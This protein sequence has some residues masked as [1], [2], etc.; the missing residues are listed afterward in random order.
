VATL[1]PQHECRDQIAI[2][3]QILTGRFQNRRCAF[4]SKKSYWFGNRYWFFNTFSP[5]R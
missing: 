2:P 5:P 4:P 3:E 1:K